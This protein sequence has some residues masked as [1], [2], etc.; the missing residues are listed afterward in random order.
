MSITEMPPFAA[1]LL[2]V[3]TRRWCELLRELA[4]FSHSCQLASEPRR[5]RTMAIRRARAT[6]R[7]ITR[8]R[9]S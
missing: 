8:M 2:T 6:T 9:G 5:L 1:R 3:V 7:A 4:I